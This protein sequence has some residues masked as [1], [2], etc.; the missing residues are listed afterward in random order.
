[1]CAL[2]VERLHYPGARRGFLGLGVGASLHS[3]STKHCLG[4]DPRWGVPTGEK[5][6]C[7]CVL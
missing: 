3:S 2:V 6:V 4:L 1:M 7:L 5:D